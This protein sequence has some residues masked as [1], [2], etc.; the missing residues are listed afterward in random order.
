MPPDAMS[1]S[2]L[3]ADGAPVDRVA[4]LFEGSRRRI[5]QIV[6]PEGVALRVEIARRGERIGAFVLDIVFLI[7]GTIVVSGGILLALHRHLP[8]DVVWTLV[9]FVA[10]V[11]RNVYFIHFELAWRGRTPGKHIMGLR[12]IDRGG[13]ALTASAVVARNLTRE[14]EVF[15]PLTLFLSLAGTSDIE[16]WQKLSILGW[17]V[18][19]AALPFFNS[20]HL[21]AGDLIGG[22]L[23]IHM[24]KRVLAPDLAVETSSF[25]FTPQQLKAYGTFELQVLEELLRQPRTAE[26]SKLYVEIVAKITRRIGWSEP[27]PKQDSER[28]LRAFY[29]AERADLEHEQLFGRARADK[30]DRRGQIARRDR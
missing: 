27:V 9:L 8:G 28:F 3:A 25:A 26:T 11:I 23:V 1:R 2:D 4:L 30:D 19:I 14:V 10:F 6:S 16:T 24:P 22:T 15:L 7:I 20:E 13:G 29:A 5:H 17:I 18:A 12:V 21:R